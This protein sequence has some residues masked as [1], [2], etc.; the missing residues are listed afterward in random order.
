MDC[1]GAALITQAEEGAYDRRVS[2]SGV[3]AGASPFDGWLALLMK[4]IAPSFTDWCL[5]WLRLLDAPS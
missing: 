2:L 5:R 1:F 3:P 4:P